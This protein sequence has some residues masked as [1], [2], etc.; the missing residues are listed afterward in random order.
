MIQICK[1]CQNVNPREASY[2]WYD[3]HLLAGSDSSGAS[4]A[5]D[6]GARPFASPFFMPSGRSCK[7][8]NE[9]ALAC[10]QDPADALD[11]I[12]RGYLEHFLAGQGRSDLGEAARVAARAPDSE[13][14]LDEFLGQLPGTALTPSRLH[15][16]PMMIDLGTLQPGEDRRFVLTL[17]NEGVRLLS[18]SASCDD[19]RWLALGDAAS[20]RR[21]VFQFSR[22]LVLPVQ[23]LGKQVARTPSTRRPRS[24]WNRAAD[25]SGSWFACS[26]RFGLFPRAS[27][28]VR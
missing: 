15:V 24:A 22:S 4:V 27:W 23:V 10:H 6:V 8:F 11:L 5:L 21:K 17:H 28:P 25:W 1:R 2:C 26:C 13:R 14:G 20:Q 19:C 9:L 7:N 16:D 12:R 18:G 3:G